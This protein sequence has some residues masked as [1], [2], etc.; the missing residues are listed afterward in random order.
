MVHLVLSAEEPA[1]DQ[2]A[3]SSIGGLHACGWPMRWLLA[4]VV[5]AR[6]VLDRAKARQQ[7]QRQQR[8]AHAPR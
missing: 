3:A 5:L 6:H 8:G 4:A 7:Q 2:A 1:A